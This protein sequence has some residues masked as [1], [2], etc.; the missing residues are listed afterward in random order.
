M[1]QTFREYT[2]RKL[3]EDYAANGLVLPAPIPG[4]GASAVFPR[5]AVDRWFAEHDLWRDRR[6]NKARLEDLAFRE[7][8]APIKAAARRA[9]DAA[10][11]ATKRRSEKV[12]QGLTVRGRTDCSRMSPEELA[13]HHRKVARDKKRRQRA[14]KPDTFLD[15]TEEQLADLEE[16]EN[17]PSMFGIF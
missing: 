12:G 16:Y 17:K 6:T 4:I 8:T 10:R 2:R 1:T 13:E 9:K 14:P 5:G 15:L 7:R 3:L 11:H